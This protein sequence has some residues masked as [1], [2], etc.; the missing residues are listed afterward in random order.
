M[1]ALS[2]LDEARFGVRSAKANDLTEACLPEVLGFCEREKVR[3]LIARCAAS[4]LSLVHKLEREGFL[5]MDTLIHCR[6]N[7]LAALPVPPDP[8][9]IRIR[10][11]QAGEEGDVRDLAEEAYRDYDG[12]YHADPR[13]DRK[14]CREAYADWALRSC[15]SR[16]DGGEVFVAETAD[17]LVGFGTVHL[18]TPHE[19]EAMLSGVAVHAQGRG[20]Y[21][22]LMT[23]CMEWSRDCGAQTML[24]TTQI[25][26][27]AVQ[28]V[29]ARL[30]F[31]PVGFSYTFHR[32][33]D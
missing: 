4:E 30:G 2:P 23:R 21:R 15:Q 16:G 14:P 11:I 22:L 8:A 1:I 28:K 9:G 5:L 12:H 29:W 7:N 32:W 3:F 25:T 27:V 20:I 10:T 24:F 17:G 31:E 26:N 6:H 13:L 19:G 33:F 18:L